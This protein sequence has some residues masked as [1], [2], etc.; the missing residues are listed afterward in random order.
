MLGA[1]WRR[2]TPA[3][4]FLTSPDPLA[5][6]LDAVSVAYQWDILQAKALW[7]AWWGQA[8]AESALKELERRSLV[9]VVPADDRERLQTHDVVRSL[10]ASIL[11]DPASGTRYYGSR[12]WNRGV[13]KFLDWSKVRCPVV[14][15]LQL[16]FQ[17]RWVARWRLVASLAFPPPPAGPMCAAGGCGPKGPG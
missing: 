1:V 13:S 17:R 9:S 14:G 16:F 2:M 3:A 10:G 4:R 8:T 15:A 6:F 5:Q 7:A 11:R 12:L